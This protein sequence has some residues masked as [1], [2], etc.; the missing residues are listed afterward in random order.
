MTIGCLRQDAK[1]GVEAIVKLLI[2]LDMAYLDWPGKSLHA[3]DE[4]IPTKSFP[5]QRLD[6]RR[7]WLERKAKSARE[8]KQTLAIGL[9]CKG[10][11]PSADRWMKR[12][13][14]WKPCAD[15][16]GRAILRPCGQKRTDED[17]HQ[18]GVMFSAV[19]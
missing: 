12:R 15:I 16:N 8:P 14:F 2:L 1:D 3:G 7:I 4:E 9:L 17:I 13:W 18:C 11:R 10:Q 6:P 19:D 5:M